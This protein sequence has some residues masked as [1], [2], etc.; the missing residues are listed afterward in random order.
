M[1]WEVTYT[2]T[3]SGVITDSE[4]NNRKSRHSQKSN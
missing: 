2:N 1:K 4:N 3:F